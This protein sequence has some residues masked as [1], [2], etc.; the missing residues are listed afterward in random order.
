M[1]IVETH[2]KHPENL[3]ITQETIVLTICKGM[4]IVVVL[5]PINMS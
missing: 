4:E 5:T 1:K 2:T 3:Y